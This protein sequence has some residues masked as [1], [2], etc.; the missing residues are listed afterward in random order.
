MRYK[1][2]KN[3]NV[4]MFNFDKTD[5]QDIIAWMDKIPEQGYSRIGYIRKLIRDRIKSGNK[6]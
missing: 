6:E 3:K 1:T 4:M 5:D 2:K